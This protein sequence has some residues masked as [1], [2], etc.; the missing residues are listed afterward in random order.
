MGYITARAYCKLEARRRLFRNN[1]GLHV[2]TLRAMTLKLLGNSD[3]A[4][5]VKGEL[6]EKQVLCGVCV[7]RRL[8]LQA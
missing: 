4:A 6:L 7:P 2:R 8:G 1:K 5:E 3:G